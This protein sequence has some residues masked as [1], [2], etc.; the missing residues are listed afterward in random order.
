[1]GPSN[2]GVGKEGE[3]ER[4]G[5]GKQKIKRSRR[6][7]GG[8]AHRVAA[9]AVRR[10]ALPAVGRRVSPARPPPTPATPVQFG[11][12]PRAALLLGPPARASREVGHPP[13]LVELGEL[14]GEQ[15]Q[16]AS[17]AAAAAPL[18]PHVTRPS[19]G[20]A[21]RCE[22]GAA[23]VRAALERHR[24]AP[25]VEEAAT[26][27]YADV[28]VGIAAPGARVGVDGPLLLLLLLLLLLILMLMLRRTGGRGDVDD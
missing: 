7:R 10:R 14:H 3:I 4:N 16:R 20:M 26:S 18:L 22:G 8:G 11:P 13:R 12:L 28:A 9:V 2:R 21:G 24:H 25:R 27:V 5:V 19:P 17:A 15:F 23:G 6:P 1:M